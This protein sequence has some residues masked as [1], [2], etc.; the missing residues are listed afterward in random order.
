MALG[1]ADVLAGQALGGRNNGSGGMS[2]AP[3]PS[4]G[5]LGGGSESYGGSGYNWQQYAQGMQRRNQDNPHYGFY[6]PQTAYGQNLQQQMGIYAPDMALSQIQQQQLMNQLGMVGPQRQFSANGLRQDFGFGMRGLGLD[7]QALGLA[8]NTAR[9]GLGFTR[10]EEAIMRAQLAN[11]QAQANSLAENQTW[12]ARSDA[13]AS[14]AMTAPGI[15]HDLGEIYG[16]LVQTREQ[17]QLGFDRDFL[18]LRQQRASY[19][20][21]LR[22][23]RIEAQRLGLSEDQLRTSL[24]RGLTQLRLDSTM[25]VNDLMSALATGNV[26]QQALVRQIIEQALAATR[27]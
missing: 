13:T 10:Q 5:G 22:S 20:D 25:T 26:Q 24:R 12:D 6:A 18:G 14:G 23:S 19:R 3:A 7:R 4:G 16:N 2:P 11:S 17:N 9:R 27:S 21:Q 8:Q 1:S 15:R